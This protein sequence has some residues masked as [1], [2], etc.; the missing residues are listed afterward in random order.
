MKVTLLS[1]IRLT[2]YVFVNFVNGIP[3]KERNIIQNTL[4]DLFGKHNR[5]RPDV[6]S[7][8]GRNETS[9]K[10]YMLDLYEY[11]VNTERQGM[12][13]FTTNSQNISNIVDDA[14]TV[15]SFLNN[16][17]V[18]RPNTT[19]ES[20]EMF[21]DVSSNYVVE[22]VLATALQVYLDITYKTVI[23]EKLI[24]SVYKIVVPKK[25]YVLL[26]SKLINASVSQWH[27]FNVLEASL[28]WIEFSETNNGILLVCQNLQKV[29][30]PIESCGIVDFKGREEF[31]PFL[32]S[33]YQSGKEEEFPAK[34][35]RNTESTLKLQERLRRSMQDSIFIEAAEQLSFVRNKTRSN[36]SENNLGSRCDKH[37][38]Y[39]GFK[40]LGWSD[41]I[42]APDGYR[43]NYCGGD[44]SFPLD[45]NANAT[46]HAIIQT[47]VHM[48]YP[49]IIPKPC[50]APNK[51]NT[52]Q[53]LFL[54]ERNNVVMKRY[55]NMI[56]QHCGCQ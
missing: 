19:D 6:F 24:I 35:I 25:K 21:F 37:P 44:C 43:A 53:V 33:F 26:A 20:G 3:T 45:N 46:N 56:V 42:I 49:E 55:S 4:L 13:N 48:M 7:H 41:W 30:I 28:S 16:A 12:N 34:Q 23:A 10:K 27:E 40:D 47:L 50:C 1:I 52:L 32:V 36:G 39:I 51:L 31:R 14:D 2:V 29:N 8:L 18:P 38:L 9:A 15:V 11:S 54:D 17:Y 5:P 22:K